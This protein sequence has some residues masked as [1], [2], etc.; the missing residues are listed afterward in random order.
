MAVAELATKTPTT[1]TGGIASILGGPWGIAASVAAPAIGALVGNLLGKSDRDKAQAIYEEMARQIESIPIPDIEKQKLFLELPQMVGEFTAQLESV[2]QLG[3]SAMKDITTDPKLRDAQMTALAKMAE[4]GETP[5]TAQEK[6]ELNASRR[7]AVREGQAQQES[8]LQNLAARGMGG[9]GQEI[10]M[11]A[12]AAQMA[13]ERQGQEGDRLAA[14]GQQRALQ[15][16]AEAG[17]LGGQVR[18]QDWG[19]SEAKARAADSIEQFNLAQRSDVQRRNVGSQNQAGLRNLSER[20]RIAEAQAQTKNQQQAQQKALLQQEFENKMKKQTAV[21]AA[22]MGQ[23]QQYQGAAERAGQMGT[24]I[25]AG[26]GQGFAGIGSYYQQQEK[27]K[28]QSA[29][30]DKLLAAKKE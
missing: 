29:L 1:P 11:R 12:Q 21:A 5:L 16:T 22:R 18:S 28:T 15:A 20:Q 7:S 23:A 3:P 25:G 8:I 17:R 19:E 6:A 30:L 13:A 26:V 14:M 10:A 4:Q 2:E 27:D 24:G 9:G